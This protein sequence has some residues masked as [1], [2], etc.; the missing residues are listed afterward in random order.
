MSDIFGRHGRLAGSL[1]VVLGYRG[2]S[3]R[4]KNTPMIVVIDNYDSFTYNLVQYL[5][6]LGSQVEV[7]RNDAIGVEDIQ[8]RM[9]QGILI[10]PGPGDPQSAGISLDV[11]RRYGSTL[12]ILGV[13]LGH[14]AIGEVYGGRVVRAEHVMHG[15]T[16]AIIHQGHGLFAGIPSP[17]NATR[18][19]S[20]LV[21]RPS[22]PA[23]LRITAT[24]PEGEIMGLEH[25]HFPVQ[26]VQFHPESFLTEHGHALLRNWLGMLPARAE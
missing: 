18:Y 4:V 2:E 20:L 26:G 8:Q 25:R 15:R 24:T 17:F 7:Y 13:C 21:D 6:E 12:P 11:V 14:Q 3:K 22:L 16:S 5:A 10:S 19:H 23:N 1:L 9:P